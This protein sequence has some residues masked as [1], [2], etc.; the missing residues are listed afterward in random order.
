MPAR[1]SLGQRGAARLHR[2]A[3]RPAARHGPPQSPGRGRPDRGGGGRR[4]PAL[5]GPPARG[6]RRPAPRRVRP[7]GRQP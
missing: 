2:P 6:R 3:D 5:A 7:A 4:R 1:R